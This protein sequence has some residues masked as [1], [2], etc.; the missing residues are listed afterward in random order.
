MGPRNEIAPQKF[1]TN[2]NGHLTNC[3]VSTRSR[4]NATAFDGLIATVQCPLRSEIKRL[5][6]HPAPRRWRVYG[7]ERQV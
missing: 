7:I 2:R 3:I 1:L 4:T 6:N 5:M